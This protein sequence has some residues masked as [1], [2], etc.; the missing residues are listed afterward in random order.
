MPV[1]SWIDGRSHSWPAA[2]FLLCSSHP[3]SCDV[4][5]M[6]TLILVNLGGLILFAVTLLLAP[7]AQ[8]P[9]AT[10]ST[11]EAIAQVEP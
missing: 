4:E 2:C 3:P 10:V 6:R 7:P 5:V 1:V 9:E 11:I 8:T